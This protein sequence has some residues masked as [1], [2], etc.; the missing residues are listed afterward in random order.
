MVKKQKKDAYTRLIHATVILL[1]L[2]IVFATGYLL[3]NR[4][5]QSELKRLQ[6][7]AALKNEELT[8]QHNQAVAEFDAAQQ[9]GENLAWPSPAASGW[10]VVDVSQFP[11]TTVRE[12]TA[13]R[14]TL[15]EGGMMLV[16]RWHELPGDFPESDVVSI[17]SVDRSIPVKDSS[18]KLFPV[19]IEA[20]SEMLKAAKDEAGLEGY[21]IQE[22]YR[23]MA[24]QTAYF[25]DAKKNYENKYSGDALIEQVSKTVSYPGTSEYQSGFAFN[26]DRWRSGD[27]EFNAAKFSTTE[28]SDWLV[29]N[30]WRYGYV[31]RFP[32]AGYPNSTVSEKSFKTGQSSHLMI[33]RYVGKANAAVMHTLD[34]CMEEYLEYLAQHPHLAVY[35]DGVL[36]YEILRVSGGD[37]AADVQLQVTQTAQSYTVSTDNMGG[38]VITMSY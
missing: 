21:V 26:V 25:D 13:S 37:T 38:I 8:A 27:K 36:K 10:D 28:H 9:M 11:L 31:F 3:L 16:N 23:T 29:A 22:G 12:I 20:L 19:A 14:Q 2:A 30:S 5:Q 33:Y 7:E 6:D 1:V 34:M 17:S 32:V 18:V 24:T 35:E 15:L 4:Y